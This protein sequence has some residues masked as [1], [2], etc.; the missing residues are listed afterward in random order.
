MVALEE[1]GNADTGMDTGMDTG[2]VEEPTMIQYD[3]AT[4]TGEHFSKFLN[5]KLQQKQNLK[6]WL[7]SFISLFG[8]FTEKA[9]EEKIHCQEPPTLFRKDVP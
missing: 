9:M 6:T 4:L 5:V 8:I 1:E 7:Y 2:A 3:G